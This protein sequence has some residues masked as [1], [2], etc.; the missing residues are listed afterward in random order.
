MTKYDIIYLTLL[1]CAFL[2]ING[3]Y[4]GLGYSAGY[5]DAICDGYHQSYE[6]PGTTITIQC[7]KE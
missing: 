7:E 3:V 2:F 5:K 4:Y 6:M 1:G